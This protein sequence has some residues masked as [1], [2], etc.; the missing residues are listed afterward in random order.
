MMIYMLLFWMMFGNHI[1]NA[2]FPYWYWYICRLQLAWHTLAVVPYTF[3]HKQYPEQ[4]N[5]TEYTEKN[6]HNNKNI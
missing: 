3:T 2:S 4:H 6:I 1:I 5:E